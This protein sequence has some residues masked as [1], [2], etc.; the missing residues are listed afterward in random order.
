MHTGA[1]PMTIKTKA[2]RP[3]LTGALHRFAS[4]ILGSGVSVAL[5]AAPFL[6]ARHVPGFEPLLS[7]FPE[8]QRTLPVA[9]STI[10][11]GLI[12]LTVQ[13]S[14]GE[15]IARRSLKRRFKLLLPFVAAGPLVLA[16]IYLW[17]VVPVDVPLGNGAF[18]QHSFIVGWVRLP[19]CECSPTEHNAKCIQGLSYEEAG[20]GSCWSERSIF[21]VKLALLLS[22][23]V[24]IEG[25][26]I[27]AGLLVLKPPPKRP[28]RR[29]QRREPTAPAAEE[30]PLTP[31][32]T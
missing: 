26:G 14:A 17:S 23:L 2:S 15:S 28:S 9:I 22:Y 1:L 29:R 10:F 24:A 27:L 7:L 32:P 31:A 25:F 21:Q 3:K 16:V 8:E 30:T 18:R 5:F 4:A 6:G 12:A 19:D 13:F 11:I 20:F